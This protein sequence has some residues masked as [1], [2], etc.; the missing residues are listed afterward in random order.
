[1]RKIAIFIDGPNFYV[2]TKA[3]GFDPDYNVLLSAL[4]HGDEIMRAYYY[5]TI[6]EDAEGVAS[7]LPLVD[8][9]DYNGYTTVTKDSKVLD[10]PGGG[11]KMLGSMN[12]ELTVDALLMAP[13]LDEMILV[14]G[15]GDLTAL[16]EAVK[17]IGVRVTVVSTIKTPKPFAANELRRAADQFVDLEV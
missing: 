11:R 6:S 10:L 1:M 5:T 7:I 2:T 3:L 13:R 9:L 16:V 12:V 8:W 4:A 14:S 15:D 17:Q